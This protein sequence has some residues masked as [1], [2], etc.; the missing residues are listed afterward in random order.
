MVQQQQQQPD[1]MAQQQAGIPQQVEVGGQ[2]VPQQQV[3]GQMPIQ[4]GKCSVKLR[5][6]GMGFTDLVH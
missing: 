4:D 5:L 3:G 1:V 2:I 6:I